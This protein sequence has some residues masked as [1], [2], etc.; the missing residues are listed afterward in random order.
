MFFEP[1][2][3]YTC[4]GVNEKHDTITIAGF[5]QFGVFEE[6]RFILATDLNKALS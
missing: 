6:K 3:V 4:T 2:K 5:E 1:G